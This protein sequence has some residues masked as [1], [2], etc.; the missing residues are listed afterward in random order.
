MTVRRLSALQW[1]G[2]FVG[3]AV[4]WAQ[5][6]LGLGITQAECSVAGAHWGIANDVWEG[7]LMGAAAAAVVVSELASLGVLRATRGTSYEDEPPLSRIR[8]FAITASVANVI[9]LMI[10]LLDGFAA[11]F[12]VTCRQG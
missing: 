10:I 1:F 3:A 11:I 5:H 12:N 9:F 7:A 2:L 4:W 8:F 6:V